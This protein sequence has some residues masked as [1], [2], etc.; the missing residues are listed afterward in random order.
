MLIYRPIGFGRTLND[1]RVRRLYET[2]PEATSGGRPPKRPKGKVLGG[3]SPTNSL[4][5]IRGQCA[6][7]ADMILGKPAFARMAA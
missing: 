6:D 4:L 5:Y 1:P 3:S 7:Y 2:E